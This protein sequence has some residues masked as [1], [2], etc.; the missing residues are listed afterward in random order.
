MEHRI[1]EEKPRI[2][3]KTPSLPTTTIATSCRRGME[4][5]T[6]FQQKIPLCSNPISDWD[7]TP[8]SFEHRFPFPL[9]VVPLFLTTLESSS[10]SLCS[11]TGLFFLFLSFFFFPSYVGSSPISIKRVM[12]KVD[13]HQLQC[14]IVGSSGPFRLLV[15][16]FFL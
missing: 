14:H 2:E 8:E 4:Q 13:D 1:V 16:L 5:S 15:C 7:Q 12:K 11:H 9:S 10:I 3:I 6:E